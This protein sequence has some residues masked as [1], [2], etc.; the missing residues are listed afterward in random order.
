MNVPGL[1]RGVRMR[2]TAVSLSSTDQHLIDATDPLKLAVM[3]ESELLSLQ[4]R[5]R[6]ARDKYSNVYRRHAAKKVREQGG[7]GAAA[8][9]S[10]YDRAKAATFDEA[11]DRVDQ[12]L[13]I[14]VPV[15][16]MRIS[17]DGG[18]RRDDL[19]SLPDIRFP[20]E[21]QHHPAAPD[22]TRRRAVVRSV[23]AHRQARRD[24]R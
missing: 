24:S 8:E 20:A 10:S 16:K 14:S 22:L 3:S 1:F 21:T 17:Y 13:A 2:P 11:L 19:K 9:Y 12:R 15:A 18:A 7:R 23:T 6:A 5:V 4:E